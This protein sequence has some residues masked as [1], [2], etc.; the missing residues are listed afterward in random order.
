VEILNSI[1]R[2]RAALNFKS[3]DKVPIWK[4]SQKSDIY[5][6]ASLPSKN[7]QPGHNEN[8]TGLFPHVNEYLIKYHRLDI[9]SLN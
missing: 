7:W 2:V 5:T 9:P 6:L 4:F 8:E 3:P 1:E